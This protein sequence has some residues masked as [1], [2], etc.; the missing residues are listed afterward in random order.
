M[1]RMP[2]KQLIEK[3]IAVAVFFV[4]VTIIL[5]AGYSPAGAKSYYHPLI[6]QTYRFYPDGIADVEE[7]RTHTKLSG[8]YMQWKTTKNKK[9]GMSW[10]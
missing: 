6:E 7:I 8:S 4:L 2:S 3:T 10:G 9:L 5:T 1:K